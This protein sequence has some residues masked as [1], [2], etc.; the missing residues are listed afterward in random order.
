M[1]NNYFFNHKNT[2]MRPPIEVRQRGFLAKGIWNLFLM[3]GMLLAGQTVK[4][5]APGGVTTGLKAWYRADKAVSPTTQWSDYSG[6][7]KNVTKAFGA[8]PLNQ[9]NATFNFNF[10]PYF[11]F[12]G[13]NGQYFHNTTGIMGSNTTP[14]SFYSVVK[15]T[16]TSGWRHIADFGNDDPS[17]AQNG[18][19]GYA[20]WRDNGSVGTLTKDAA[21]LP[22]HTINTMWSASG[23]NYLDFN[24]LL[25][26]QLSNSGGNI[27]DNEFYLGTEGF[28]LGTPTGTGNGSELYLGGMGEVIVYNVNHALT[29][30]ERQ[31]I[32][33]YLAIKYGTTLDQSTPQN[34]L[35]SDGTVLWNATTNAG[36]KTN[37]AGVGRDDASALTQLI[38]KS[39][40]TGETVPL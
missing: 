20:I 33:S 15:S 32:N 19:T 16:A 4:A 27:T 8:I 35:A 13:G 40:N 26:A 31:K 38:S 39:V 25:T 9:S 10:N 23:A 2:T 21:T 5:Q 28:N 37:I 18:A 22:T 11:E 1:K 34:Y 3:A 24:G 36:Y 14:G 17:L 7:G 12:A 30:T 29:T 6:N